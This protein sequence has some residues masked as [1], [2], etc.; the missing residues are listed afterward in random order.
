MK[1]PFV[2]SPYNYDMQAASDE[3][4]LKCLDPSM[5]QQQFLEESDINTIVERF[6]LNG[7]LPEV[8]R[9]PQYGDFTQVKD[10]QSAL[11]AVREAEASFMEL[12]ARVR[13]R[14][15]NDPQQLLEFVAD[16]RNLVE[17]RELGLVP[18]AP[19]PVSGAA[20]P[21]A[22]AGGSSTAS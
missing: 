18:P 11:N 4:G 6:G 12:P 14:F 9:V 5:A 2:R 13:A 19:V 17:A 20:L 1:A 22:A 21:A 16:G 7:E 15:E 8:V 10:F 3:S